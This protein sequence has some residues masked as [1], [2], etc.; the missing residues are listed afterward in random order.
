MGIIEPTT[1]WAPVCCRCYGKQVFPA[2]VDGHNPWPSISSATP[3]TYGEAVALWGADVIVCEPHEWDNRT[4]EENAVWLLCRLHVRQLLAKMTRESII[5][6]LIRWCNHLIDGYQPFFQP[7]AASSMQEDAEA[8]LTDPLLDE[9][10]PKLLE[11]IIKEH[12]LE[13]LK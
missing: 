8:A 5:Y 7:E 1:L 12:H 6:D 4:T 10:I 2:M 11:Q 13:Y 9:S 3:Q